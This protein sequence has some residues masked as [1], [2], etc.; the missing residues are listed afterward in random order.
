MSGNDY[1]DHD[2]QTDHYVGALLEDIKHML[3]AILEGQRSMVPVLDDIAHI[4]KDVFVAQG[5][6]AAMKAV[7][8]DHEKLLQSHEKTLQS[9]EKTLQSHEE[10]MKD[11][12]R[13]LRDHDRMMRNHD[14]R[15]MRLETARA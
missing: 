8:K 4:E 14:R 6:V 3:T 10:L 7:A 5:E 12:K 9:H 1:T 13:H 2:H 15:M 11:H